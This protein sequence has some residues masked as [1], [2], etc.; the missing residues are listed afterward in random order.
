MRSQHPAVCGHC[1]ESLESRRL[2]SAGDLDTSFAGDGIA[3][4]PRDTKILFNDAVVLTNDKVLFGGGTSE[5]FVAD[6]DSYVLRRFNADGTL[7]T[8]FGTNGTAT[9]HFASGELEDSTI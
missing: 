6:Q 7:D 2:L 4:T 8:T 1:V 9:G 3:E 5:V